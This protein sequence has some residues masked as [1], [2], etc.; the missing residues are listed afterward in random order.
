MFMPILQSQTSKLFISQNTKV[1]FSIA[2]FREHT[3]KLC[4]H[5]EPFL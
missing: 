5:K 2:Y 1:S 3:E 4:I